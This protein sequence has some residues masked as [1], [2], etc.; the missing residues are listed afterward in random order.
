MTSHAISPLE[1][2]P[3]RLRCDLIR[4]FVAGT[5]EPSALEGVDHAYM[6]AIFHETLA[7]KPNTGFFHLT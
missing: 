3:Y 5:I 6:H 2:D 7:G 4:W 1:R